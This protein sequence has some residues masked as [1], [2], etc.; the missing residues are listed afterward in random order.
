MKNSNFKLLAFFILGIISIN[1]LVGQNQKPNIV[2]ILADDLGWGDLSCYGQP[3][4]KTPALDKMATQGIR[5]ERFYVTGVTCCPSRTGFMTSRHPA[6]YPKYMAENGFAGK[7]TVTEIFKNNGYTTGHF[8]KWHIGSKSSEKNG[9]YGIDEVQVIGGNNSSDGG[10]DADLFEAAIKFIEKNKDKP[11]YV[12]IWGHITHYAVDPVSSLVVPFKDVQVKRSDFGKHMQQKF[13]DCESLGGDV[14][15]SMRNYLGDVYSLDI[16]VGRVLKKL[17]E[18]GLSENTIVIFSSDQ[19]PAPVIVGGKNLKDKYKVIGKNTGICPSQN[20]LGYA[21]GLRGGKHTQ[22]EGGVR[23]PLIVRWQGKIPENIVNSSSIVSGIDYL[24]TICNLAGIDYEDEG[25]EGEDM[26]KVILGE[27]G[28]RTTPLFWRTSSGK[29]NPSMLDGNWK[30]H[31]KGQKYELYDLLVDE[32]EMNNVADKYPAKVKELSKQME[33][34][35]ST[36][37]TSYLKKKN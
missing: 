11:F 30:L 14:E 20:M 31:R 23:S 12:N 10:R 18:L 35:N 13:D 2:F 21:G 28:Q 36:L 34:W 27:K 1:N 19:G 8:G 9:T 5:F 7:T 6:S 29:A 37:P 32:K 4:S 17:E 15:E 25:F 22:W 16:Q 3:Y 33:D 26:S 24:P